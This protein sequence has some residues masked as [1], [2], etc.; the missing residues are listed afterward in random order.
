MSLQKN[1]KKLLVITADYISSWIGK[2]EVVPGYF[3]PGNLFEEIHLILV[4]DDK[5]D[6]D[7]LSPLAGDAKVFLYNY[8]APD[9]FF[10]KTL[11]W[12]PFLMK[13]WAKGAQD[14]ARKIAPDLIRCY[15][16]HLSTFLGVSIKHNLN[17]PCITSLHGN[18]D[19]DYMRSRLARTLKDKITGICQIFIEKF[20]LKNL[21]HIICVYSPIIEY[22]KKH[23]YNNFSV[24]YN[25][26]GLGAPIKSDFSLKDGKIR[27]LCVGR[28]TILQKNPIHIVEAV[29]VIPNTYLTLIGSGDLHEMLK[30]KAEDLGCAERV[31]FHKNLPNAEIVQ[32]MKDFD[33]FI[34][35]SMNYELSKGCIEAALVGLPVILNKRSGKTADEIIEAGFY[36]VQDTK[37]GYEKAIQSVAGNVALREKLASKGHAYAMQNW[38][39]HINE[40]KLIKLYKGFLTH[41]S[42][43][44]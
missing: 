22:L 24:I 21:D 2:G 14:L 17:I 19:A 42:D 5:P 40:E 33:I 32:M 37:A 34:Y 31:T 16:I 13:S 18:P 1:P 41:N 15:G 7:S 30:K 38:S 29:S 43:L 35:H 10:K 12:Q 6:L 20:C 27:L 23:K 11:G 9:G 36:L 39:P 8:P 4:N 26:V 3:N 25:V 28:Q 44:P